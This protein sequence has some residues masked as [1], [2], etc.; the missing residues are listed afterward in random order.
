MT[1]ETTCPII[2]GLLVPVSFVALVKSHTFDSSS[3]IKMRGF[4]IG[5]QQQTHQKQTN[6]TTK[7]SKNECCS[8]NTKL[9]HY[10]S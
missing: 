7:T 10:V 6:T 3:F 8:N 4:T 1:E 9:T 2:D 5:T